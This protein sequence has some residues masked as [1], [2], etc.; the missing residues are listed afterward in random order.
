VSHLLGDHVSTYNKRKKYSILPRFRLSPSLEAKKK[1]LSTQYL[2]ACDPAPPFS[3]TSPYL[4][5]K[6]FLFVLILILLL[7]FLS[8]K[9]EKSGFFR[10][11]STWK[12]RYA[13]ITPDGALALFSSIETSSS[14]KPITYVFLHRGAY[15]EDIVG[16]VDHRDF[17]FRLVTRFNKYVFSC[18][19]ERSLDNWLNALTDEI[20]RIKDTTQDPT[21][22]ELEEAGLRVQSGDLEYKKRV[23]FV[24]DL[25][26]EYDKSDTS[27]AHYD[28]FDARLPEDP[29]VVD[30]PDE[31]ELRIQ[32]L[33][34]ETKKHVRFDV[35]YTS[36]QPLPTACPVLLPPE[37][38]SADSP[39]VPESGLDI[40]I[41]EKTTDL[42]DQSTY[43]AVVLLP[44]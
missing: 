43:G 21:L 9:V 36:Q 27:I 10:C 19:S 20:I 8:V 26:K 30:T 35:L 7:D 41:P 37:A 39:V 4:T 42:H 17:S 32:S 34:S 14:N 29:A 38:P 3:G 23:H 16:G 12:N 18:E 44:M 40:T 31:A 11:R 6:L 22:R 1:Q 15:V 24:L 28:E 25:F 2:E 13:V 5:F 33:D